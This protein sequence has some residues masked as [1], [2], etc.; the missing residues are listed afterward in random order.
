MNLAENV[1]TNTIKVAVSFLIPRRDT[2]N[3]K[4][5]R[6]NLNNLCKEENISHHNMNTRLRFKS[7]DLHLN[8]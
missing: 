6:V 5:K 2:F 7:R 8:G 3:Q 4:V 1:K